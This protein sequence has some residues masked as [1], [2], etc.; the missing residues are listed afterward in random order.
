MTRRAR[1]MSAMLLAVSPA[2]HA[3]DSFLTSLLH[4]ADRYQW[5]QVNA[6]MS[7][8]KYREA[9]RHNRRLARGMLTNT[10]VSLG[11]PKMGVNLMGAA[12]AIAVDDLKL[13]LNK[14]VALE[15]EDPLDK[16]RMG[17]F[18]EVKFDW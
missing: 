9:F 14:I 1:L 13:D 18:I 17:A 12:V 6:D 3:Q 2:L 16:D 8:G 11:V 15:M 5:R 10:I 7:P 4:E